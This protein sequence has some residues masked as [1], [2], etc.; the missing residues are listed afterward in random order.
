MA[1]QIYLLWQKKIMKA[2]S[3]VLP[4]TYNRFKTIVGFSPPLSTY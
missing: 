4:E 1:A 2:T 3:S